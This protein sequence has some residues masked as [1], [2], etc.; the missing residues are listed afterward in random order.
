M[1][2]IDYGRQIEAATHRPDALN[3]ERDRIAGELDNLRTLRRGALLR[4]QF[5]REY[6]CL[7]VP[8]FIEFADAVA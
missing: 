3:I 7:N 5:E 8:T 2:S 4:E 1:T 6:Q